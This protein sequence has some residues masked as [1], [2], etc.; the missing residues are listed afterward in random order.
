[1]K[2]RKVEARLEEILVIASQFKDKT[3]N[4]ME[5]IQGILTWLETTKEPPTNAPVKD[6]E[7]MQLE[8]EL[9][10]FG[11]KAAENLIEAVKKTKDQF[12]VF[13]EKVLTTHN[14]CQ[15]SSK[16]RLDEFPAHKEHLKQL[17]DRLQEDE[18]GIQLIKSLHD[19]LLKSVIAQ[20]TVNSCRLE[21]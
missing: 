10:G 18:L 6:S 12:M 5:I 2:V 13:C 20:A 9:M 19:K 17:H 7:R 15:T 14:K 3:Q 4:V 11:N 21:D 16:K 1:M 8:Y